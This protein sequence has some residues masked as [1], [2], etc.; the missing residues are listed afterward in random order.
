SHAGNRSLA[1]PTGMSPEDALW[2]AKISHD[3]DRSRV[4]SIALLMDATQRGRPRG[5]GDPYSRSCHE[6]VDCGYGFRL[7]LAWA[8]SAGTTAVVPGACHEGADSV[9]ESPLSRGRP[10]AHPPPHSKTA[11]RCRM[12]APRICEERQP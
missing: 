7:S 8:R 6:G 12:L 10:P 4:L 3:Y 11:A 1:P 9:H 5:S 2:R